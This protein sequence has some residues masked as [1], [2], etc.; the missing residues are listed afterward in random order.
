MEEFLPREEHHKG[1]KTTITDHGGIRSKQIR[2]I[3]REILRMTPG[4][5]LR[6]DRVQ[7]PFTG[8]I[9]IHRIIARREATVHL[10]AA[11]EEQPVRVHR[12]V[13]DQMVERGVGIN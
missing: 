4:V 8:M 1:R 6:T 7:I 13:R 3:R 11:V 10:I 2:P 9:R 5:I 12:Q